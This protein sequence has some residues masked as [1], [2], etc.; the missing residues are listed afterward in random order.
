VLATAAVVVSVLL[1]S[2][3]FGYCYSLDW[4]RRLL[5]TAKMWTVPLSEEQLTYLESE[6]KL[7]Q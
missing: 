2:D 4:A 1:S 5:F 7:K 6:S 3:A